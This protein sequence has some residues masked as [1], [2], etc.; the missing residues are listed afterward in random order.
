MDNPLW[1]EEPPMQGE[2]P[3]PS[4]GQ[5]RTVDYEKVFGLLQYDGPAL[6]ITRLSFH[7]TDEVSE[8]DVGR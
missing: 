7:V 1:T 2:T 5:Y 8:P 6:P 4:S 3:S